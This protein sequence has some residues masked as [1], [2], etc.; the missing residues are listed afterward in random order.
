M[1]SNANMLCTTVDV[2]LS[3]NIQKYNALII[4][5]PWVDPQETPR[6]IAFCDKQKPFKAPG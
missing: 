3:K 6:G 2:T 5:S 4:A 1:S